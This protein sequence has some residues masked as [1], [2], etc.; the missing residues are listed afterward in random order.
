MC[1]NLESITP[2]L[3]EELQKHLELTKLLALISFLGGYSKDV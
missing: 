1:V 3:K 2:I